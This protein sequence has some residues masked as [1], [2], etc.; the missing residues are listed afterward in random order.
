MAT[1]TFASCA[2]LVALTLA[3]SAQTRPPAPQPTPA[4]P[5]APPY[6]PDFVIQRPDASEAPRQTGQAPTGDRYLIGPQDNLSIIVIDENDLTGKY[7]VD[8]DGTLMFPYLGRV[9]V[10][11]LTIDELQTKLTQGLQAG[12]LRNPQ[13][14]IE[15]DQFKSRSVLVTGEVRSPGKV[16]LTSLTMSLLEALALAGSP[17][18]N[19]ANEVIVVHAARPGEKPNEP[20]TVNRKDLELGKAGMDVVLQDGDI[21]NVPIAKR[22]WISGFVKNP[23]NYVL[24]V[25][26]NVAQAIIL[27]GGLNDRGSD[28][29]LTI[30]RY[31]NGKLTEISAKLEDKIQPD[32]EVKIGSR[33]F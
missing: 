15:I 11:G 19:A 16:S 6:R 4:Q 8:N 17:T 26:T 27:A 3:T 32:D 2:C 28:R 25:G 13:I 22:F 9:R 10:A 31:V 20:I 18:G 7:R 23:G 5:P 29:R 14:R 21:I 12:Y 33:L 1:R 24:D 30:S